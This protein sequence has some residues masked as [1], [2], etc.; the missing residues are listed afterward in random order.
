MSNIEN[1]NQILEETDSTKPQLTETPEKERDTGLSAA[2][3]ERSTN[4]SNT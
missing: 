2:E 4:E 3:M 1:A